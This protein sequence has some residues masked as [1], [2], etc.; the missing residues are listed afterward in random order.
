MTN[1]KEDL[2][3]FRKKIDDI[4]IEIVGLLKKR[5]EIVKEVGHY[6]KQ[7]SATQSFIRAGREATMLRNLVKEAKDTFP[8]EAI[9]TMWRMIISTSLATEQEMSVSSY[10]SGQDKSCFWLAREYFG[11][12]LKITQQESADKVIKDVT[13]GNASVGVLPLQDNSDKP[14][15]VRPGKEKNDVYIFARI[16]FV[17]T[18]KS[19]V[20]SAL[21]IANVMP[22]AT[23]DDISIISIHTTSPKENIEKFFANEGLKINFIA[24]HN[25]KDYLVEINK[26]LHAG[27]SA[28]ESI[29]KHLDKDSVIRF[30]GAYATPIK[31]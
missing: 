3:S 20:P 30:M 9:A 31:L 25:G 10:S 17:E 15:W 22:E 29:K 14:W 11:S 8:A 5:M 24:V 16:P 1:K 13:A 7:T 4:D 26:F 28:I 6:K 18:E 19:K 21:A 27:E 2:S 23:N 12:F